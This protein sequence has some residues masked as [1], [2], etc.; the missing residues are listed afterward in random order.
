MFYFIFRRARLCR[1]DGR[2]V[3]AVVKVDEARED[4]MSNAE[5]SKSFHSKYIEQN[6]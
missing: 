1:P 4:A 6:T 5:E 3:Q 2:S